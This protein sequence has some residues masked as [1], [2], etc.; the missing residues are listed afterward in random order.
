MVRRSRSWTKQAVVVGAL[1]LLTT[2]G[3]LA[4]RGALTIPL[5]VDQLVD[6]ADRIVEGSIV[7][8]KIEPHPQY[9]N[10]NTAVITVNV[11]KTLKGTA[12]G[13]HT[14]R[15][16]LWNIRD[17]QDG[18]GYQKGSNVL[19]ML[20]QT[21]AIGLT[22]PVGLTQGRFRILTVQG[23]QVAIN[24]HGNYNLFTDTAAKLQRKGVTLD[25]RLAQVVATQEEVGGP[26]ELE[27][28]ESLISALAGGN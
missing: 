9:P 13:L 19:L 15:Q 16:Y 2:T 6:Q 3:L 4:Q 8:A 17:L 20:N 11:K 26:V 14:Y 28:F 23:E 12:E 27:A 22:S 5:T 10:L 7:S 25:A 18:A 21:S 1:L 24:G